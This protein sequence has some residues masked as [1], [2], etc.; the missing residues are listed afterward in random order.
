M[1]RFCPLYLD[2]CDRSCS[3]KQMQGCDGNFTTAR[4]AGAREFAEWLMVNWYGD[5]SREC[6]ESHLARFLAA[7]AGKK[8]KEGK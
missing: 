5:Y 8:E 2:E 7:T 4:E 1:K 6:W 3:E